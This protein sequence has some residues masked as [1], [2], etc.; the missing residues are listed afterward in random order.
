MS[1]EMV[2]AR[3]NGEFDLILPKHRAA[4]PEWYA[5]KGWEK[6]RLQS[7]H[8]NVGSGDVVY[9]IGSELG[10]MSALCSLW[11]ADVVNFEPNYR[12]WPLIKATWEANGLKLPLA[13]FCGF[14]SDTTQLE[15][16]S[17]DR[18]IYGGRQW[19]LRD[20]GWP[21]CVD[22]EIVEAHGFNQLY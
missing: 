13:N 9:Y 7:M 16:P 20:D 4:R 8:Q 6:A 17:P 18:A 21:I 3:L 15:P 22:G 12:S 19:E 11:G 5:D 10:E 14:A 2:K 1:A